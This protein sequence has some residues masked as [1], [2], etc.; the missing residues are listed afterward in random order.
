MSYLDLTSG[1]GTAPLGHANRH[2]LSAG[3]NQMLPYQYA[4]AEFP[5]HPLRAFLAKELSNVTFNQWWYRY[6]SLD[7]GGIG[8]DWF[9]AGKAVFFDSEVEAMHACI[10]IALR[11]AGRHGLATFQGAGHVAECR[12]Q[13]AS[14][15][16]QPR[17]GKASKFRPSLYELPFPE[18]ERDLKK[19]ER[20]LRSLF[21]GNR[22][23]AVVTEPIQVRAGVKIPPP[24]F[25]GLLRKLTEENEAVLIFD[26][27]LTAF[28]RTGW[29]FAC[30]RDV[31]LPDIVCLGKSLASGFPLTACI[32]RSPI[33]DK[34]VAGSGGDFQFNTDGGHP[35]GCA[36][37]LRQL[38]ELT[39]NGHMHQPAIQ[40]GHFLLKRL[41]TIQAPPGYSVLVRGRGLLA[42]VEI[43]HI[44]GAPAADLTISV[45]KIMLQRGYL[46]MRGGEHHNV[47]IFA[48][49]LTITKRHLG[50]AVA[51]LKR[52]IAEASDREIAP[53][54]QH[55]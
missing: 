43:M 10:E 53:R 29:T 41:Q 13:A 51:E 47:I 2:I 5:L 45:L 3:A 18:T 1:R 35:L 23:G 39:R 15:F 55:E 33:M 9:Q 27:R 25:L 54:P 49:P 20:K 6:K 7:G 26:E 28:G 37:A 8:P 40:L 38:E 34:A 17:F 4:E 36:M 21:R 16:S 19:V 24:E 46:L 30:E 31:S 42:A 22:I 48:P 44:D 52:V 14:E 32:V 12:K 11:A 50:A